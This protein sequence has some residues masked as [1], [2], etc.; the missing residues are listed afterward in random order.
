MV[1]IEAI[2]TGW[3]PLADG[4]PPGWA[5]GWGQDRYGVFVELTLEEVIQRLRW[6]RPGRFLMGSPKDE[7]GRRDDEGPQYPVTIR[8]GFWLFE[9]PCTQ[10][11]WQAVMGDNPS[12]FRSPDRPVEGVSWNDVQRFL[13]QINERIPGLNLVL[14][15]EAQ[16]E[17]ACRAGTETALYT[18][19]IEILGQANAP[20][21][22]PIA[23][24]GGN[25]GVD[26]ELENGHDSSSWEEKQYPHERAGT[27]PVKRK[28]PNPW[29]LYDLLGNVWEWTQD[30]WHASYQSAPGDGSAWEESDPRAERV[31]RGGSWIGNA[32]SVRS[33][34]RSHYHPDFRDD[35]LGFRPA[36]R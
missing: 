13:E 36:C 18:G 14:P 24:Y 11:L 23:W 2:D 4:C 12:R 20:A 35:F 15:T 7:P 9:T 6:I 31:L 21:L 34:S 30:H 27:H 16:W 29:G 22:N 1:A 10:A 19:D 17:Y 8:R 3:H 28:Q 26:F 25:S 32:R 33:A 5:S